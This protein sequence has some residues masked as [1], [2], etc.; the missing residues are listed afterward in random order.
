MKI[1]RQD[2]ESLVKEPAIVSEDTDFCEKVT[3]VGGLINKI[4]PSLYMDPLFW[5][6]L[7][8]HL[9]TNITLTQLLSFE[10]NLDIK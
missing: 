5:H 3:V 1:K 7:F 4:K 10:V 6:I 9:F 8:D 2:S